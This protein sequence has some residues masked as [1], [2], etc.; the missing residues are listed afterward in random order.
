[1]SVGTLLFTDPVGETWEVED[2]DRT[3]LVEM[4]DVLDES[5]W[6]VSCV[7]DFVAT[8]EVVDAVIEV[9]SDR[10]VLLGFSGPRSSELASDEEDLDVVEVT[11]LL[12]DGTWVTETDT[13]GCWEMVMELEVL[14]DGI[15]EEDEWEIEAEGLVDVELVVVSDEVVS[16]DKGA[17]MGVD[18][19][20]GDNWDDCWLRAD[21][22]DS[23]DDEM[24]VCTGAFSVVEL[25]GP[26]V[27]ELEPDDAGLLEALGTELVS[28]FSPWP[29]AVRE[30]GLD[31]EESVT[32]MIS[33]VVCLDVAGWAFGMVELERVTK[34]G[35]G[36]EFWPFPPWP[37]P[38]S[39]PFAIDTTT[40][41]E[42]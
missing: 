34:I 25:G 8:A 18:E 22:W 29:I 33:I 7:E 2:E 11:R 30:G 32:G 13:A 14:A 16:E 6:E 20:V 40:L 3:E 23:E 4:E 26:D 1:M 39:P 9:D 38:L 15:T 35:L 28:E 12:V 17:W 21:V 10:L 41:L 37:A 27:A 5:A 36:V 31:V 19:V 24:G 42:L